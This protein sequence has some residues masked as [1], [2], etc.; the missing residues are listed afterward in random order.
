MSVSPAPHPTRLLETAPAPPPPEEALTRRDRF[1][2][3]LGRLLLRAPARVQLALVGKPQIR[4]DGQK[5]DAEIQVLSVDYRLA[6]EHPFPAGVHDALAAFR[7]AVAHASELGADP[8]RVAVGGDSAGGNLSAATAQLAARDGGPAPTLQLL[9]YP[10]LD[11]TDARTASGRMF[12]NGFLLTEHDLRWC[13]RHYLSGTER[14]P[15]DP[16]VSPMFGESLSGLAPAIMITAG[17]D[18]LRDEGEA[19]AEA[20]HKAGTRVVLERSPDLIHGF[21][22]MP[23]A[24]AAR[25]AVLRLAG[26]VR[27]SLALAR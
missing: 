12:A 15:A 13:I 2:A 27:A 9:I 4:L 14:D 18:P 21:I 3:R 25:D 23:T 20:L 11:L 16:R 7:W 22:N 26:M 8:Y 6:P 19:Y 1:E 10:A 24:P 5:L 17:F